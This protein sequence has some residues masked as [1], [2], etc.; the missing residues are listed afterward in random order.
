V[1]QHL[2]E[3]VEGPGAPS[4]PSGQAGTEVH[5]ST[6]VDFRVVT[7]KGA[8]HALKLERIFWRVLKVA[9]TARNERLGA[10][11]AKIV[12][13]CAAGDNK[14][15]LVRVHVVTWLNQKLIEISG[16]SVTR[17]TLN[18]LVNAAPVPCF[19]IS[20]QNRIDHQ[21]EAFLGLL[22]QRLEEQSPGRQPE[23]RIGFQS[24]FAT[25]LDNLKSSSVNSVKDRLFLHVGAEKSEHQARIVLLESGAATSLGMLVYL[26][27]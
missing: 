3:I 12:D 7:H 4:S 17:K 21:N 20:D 22:K 9:A 2:P 24:N 6:L 16:E 27:P 8:R 23:I 1:T 19:I 25:L 10:Y 5:D 13:H 18:N 26:S 14:T 15:S 11:V